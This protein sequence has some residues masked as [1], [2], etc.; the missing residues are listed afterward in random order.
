MKAG[1][2]PAVDE[3]M[4]EIGRKISQELGK[5]H[6]VADYT[7]ED[8]KGEGQS[9]VE[10][11]MKL[12]KAMEDGPA[13][14][15]VDA[16][17]EEEEEISGDVKDDDAQKQMDRAGDE[18]DDEQGQD[19]PKARAPI[20][21]KVKVL[22]KKGVVKKKKAAPAAAPAAEAAPAPETSGPKKGKKTANLKSK[23]GSSFYADTDVK[24]KRKKKGGGAPQAPKKMVLH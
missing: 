22:K 23:T 7:I 5:I 6:V 21:K 9:K 19:E 14:E 2:L 13:K 20:T 3:E 12:L 24:G 17:E 11:D 10:V 4:A 1:K 8:K 15:Y 16:A 18:H